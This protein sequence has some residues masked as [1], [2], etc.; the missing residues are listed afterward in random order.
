MVLIMGKKLRVAIVGCGRISESY[1]LCFRKLGGQME[2]VAAVD[3]KKER[4][5]AYASSFPGCVPLTDYRDLFPLSIDVVHLCLP[6]YLHAPVAIDC[7]KHGINV[8]TEKPMALSVEDADAMIEAARS[9]DRKLSCVFQTRYYGT[10]GLLK[11]YIEKKTYGKLLGVRSFLTWRRDQDYY[12]SSDWKGTWEKE[13]GGVLIDQAIHS[14]DRVLYCVPSRVISVEGHRSNRTHPYIEVEDEFDACLHFENEVDYLLY[15]TDSYAGNPPIQIEFQA[16]KA[17]YGLLQDEAYLD[18]EGKRTTF[19]PEQLEHAGE[20]YWGSTHILQIE[21][22]Y[23]YVRG[24]RDEKSLVCSAEDGRN[25]LRV[26][27]ALYESAKRNQKI[28]L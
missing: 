16:E 3:A 10:V 13:G 4:A 19:E 7:L 5:E 15:A 26:V 1:A 25:T 24:E 20:S 14:L 21:E 28:F 23:Q 22:F 2:L 8:L 12:S 17:A 18:F 9:H 6:H 27:M 11:E